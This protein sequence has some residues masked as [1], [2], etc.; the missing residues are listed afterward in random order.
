MTD[1]KSDSTNLIKEKY[2]FASKND[3]SNK[4]KL[5]RNLQSEINK[6]KAIANTISNKDIPITE[7]SRLELS[8][9]TLLK[10]VRK[11]KCQENQ[12]Y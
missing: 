3:F 9:E 1:R 7:L 2:I 12:Q 6:I 4:S 5:N 11:L 10:Q 8:L